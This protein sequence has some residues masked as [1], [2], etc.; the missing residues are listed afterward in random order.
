[1]E[2]IYQG[3]VSVNGTTRI[4][5]TTKSMVITNIIINNPT[6]PY[7]FTLNRFKTT[8]GVNTSVRIYKFELDAGDSIRDTGSYILFTGNYL[9]LISDVPGT[10]Y[11]ISAIQS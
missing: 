1:M 5:C 6:D 3:T 4:N 9:Q 8:P 7:I 2:I 10:T 11:Y